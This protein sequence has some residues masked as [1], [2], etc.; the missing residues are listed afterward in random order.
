MQRKYIA[1]VLLLL[2]LGV[3]STLAL[4]YTEDDL[5]EN[6]DTIYTLQYGTSDLQ[7]SDGS[8]LV[9]SGIEAPESHDNDLQVIIPG[10]SGGIEVTP[11]ITVTPVHDASG[12]GIY[13]DDSGTFDITVYLRDASKIELDTETIT[14]SI[15]GA[16]QIT[17]TATF[18]TG[19]T[20]IAYV[21]IQFNFPEAA[22]FGTASTPSGNSFES[23]YNGLQ[24]VVE[25][26]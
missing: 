9:T 15:S 23:Y 16:T 19:Y 24:I 21:D 10:S 13:T 26:A 18:S 22:E 25:D 1:A 6:W 5:T 17:G 8:G 3:M 20:N 14:V 4:S 2:T 7:L 12:A 11:K